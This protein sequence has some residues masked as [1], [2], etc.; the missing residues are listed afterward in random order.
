MSSA[1][2]LTLLAATVAKTEAALDNAR[3]QLSYATICAPISGVI[4][5]VSTEEGE[6]V[7]AGLNAPTFVTILDLSRLHD[8]LRAQHLLNLELH[9]V[10]VFEHEGEPVADRDP[11]GTLELDDARP[12]LLAD[13]LVGN[14]VQD[15]LCLMRF[16][17]VPPGHRRR[18]AARWGAGRVVP[19]P[20]GCAALPVDNRSRRDRARGA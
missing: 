20:P 15:L 11:A 19:C 7:A 2:L 4:G 12:E 10:A 18:A 3:A 14:Q 16:T 1:L 9:A 8:P 6:T 17:R 13:P 5:S